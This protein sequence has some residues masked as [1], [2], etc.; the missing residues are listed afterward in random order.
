MF[1]PECKSEYKKDI[2]FCEDCNTSLVEKLPDE[3]PTEEVKWVPLESISGDIYAEM[4]KE[5]LENAFIPC[6]IKTDFMISAFGI[7]GSGIP[8]TKAKI[9]VPEE[10]FEEASEILYGMM[11]NDI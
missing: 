8:I 5:S 10:S 9:Y 1:C 11:E 7:R 3:I 4:V 2:L 6:Y